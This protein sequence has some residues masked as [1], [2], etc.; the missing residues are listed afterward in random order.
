MQD[1][2]TFSILKKGVE[3]TFNESIVQNP[4][5]VQYSETLDGYLHSLTVSFGLVDA[6]AAPRRHFM[7]NILQC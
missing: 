7:I 6:L 5:H 4:L 1:Y 3:H 2:L